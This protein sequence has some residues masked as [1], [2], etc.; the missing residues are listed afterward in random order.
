MRLKFT[1]PSF[2]DSHFRT[3]KFSVLVWGNHDLCRS[4]LKVF[5]TLNFSKFANLIFL[6]LLIRTAVICSQRSKLKLEFMM[7]VAS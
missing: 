3:T 4:C 7:I 1:K 6:S 5:P 2:F